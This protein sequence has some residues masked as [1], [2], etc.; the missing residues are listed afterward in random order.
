MERLD[1]RLAQAEAAAGTL[2]TLQDQAGQVAGLRQQVADRDRLAR[3]RSVAESS[4]RQAKAAVADVGPQLDAWRGDF[5]DWVRQGWNLLGQLRT[6]ESRFLPALDTAVAG[7]AALVVAESHRPGQFDETRFLTQ[8]S[9]DLAVGQLLER[10]GTS[11]LDPFSDVPEGWPRAVA[12][13]ALQY[14]GRVY[15]PRLGFLQFQR[16]GDRPRSNG[17]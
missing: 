11:D 10:L 17:R 3:A 8:S 9:A 6:L 12:N 16:R 1:E 14:V 15:L 13:L 7:T 5:R 2:R 4:E